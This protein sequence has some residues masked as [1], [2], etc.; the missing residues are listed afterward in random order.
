[1]VGV[2]LSRALGEIRPHVNVCTRS[3]SLNYWLQFVIVARVVCRVQNI[4][5]SGAGRCH[6]AALL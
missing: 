1:M 3:A 5:E 4:Q 2:F 6:H